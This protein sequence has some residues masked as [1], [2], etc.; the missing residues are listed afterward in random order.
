MFSF[1]DPSKLASLLRSIVRNYA[2]FASY[3]WWKD[4]Y[5]VRQDE[6]FTRKSFCQLC[7][8]LHENEENKVYEDLDEWWNR[9]G[10]CRKARIRN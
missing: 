3:F 6:K 5:T 2:E 10:K 7:Q 4:H 9:Q 1:Q 8:E